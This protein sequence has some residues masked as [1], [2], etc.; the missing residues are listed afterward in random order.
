MIIKCKSIAHIKESLKYIEKDEKD[1]M[2]FSSYGV[3]ITNQKTILSDFAMFDSPKVKNKFVSMVIS[4]NKLDNLNDEKLKQVL[5]QTIKEL[6][7]TNRSY[8][9][10]KHRNTENTHLHVY[11][12]RISHDGETWN[13]SKTAKRCKETGIKITDEMNLLPYEIKKEDFNDKKEINSKYSKEKKDAIKAL[14]AIVKDSLYKV[15]SIDELFDKI[16]SKG[17]NIKINEL[18]NG[19]FGV[20]V[21]Y[22]N[23]DIKASDVSRYLTVK[24]KEGSYTANN[25]LQ[26]VIDLNIARFENRRGKE[27][28]E[29]EILMGKGDL[30]ELQKELKAHYIFL[31]DTY[32]SKDLSW[33]EELQRRLTKKYSRRKR[34]TFRL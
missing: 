2:F 34:I 32:R 30:V 7:L 28:I 9:C 25:K 1:H 24:E 21:T 5:H 19:L 22:R 11:L 23:I 14:Q 3:D 10:V 26:V 13:D 4:P 18:K 15:V 27:D 17:A 31:L 8:Y 12:C 16:E 33:E 29:K 6:G 20:T